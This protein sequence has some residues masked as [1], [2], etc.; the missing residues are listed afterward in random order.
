MADFVFKRRQRPIRFSWELDQDGCFRSFSDEFAQL[1]GPQDKGLIGLPFD[2]VRKKFKMG[3]IPA[4]TKSIRKQ[5]AFASVKVF[6]PACNSNKVVPI[7]LTGQPYMDEAGQF[8]G[9]HGFGV[10]RSADA[11]KAEEQVEPL[12]VLK[13]LRENLLGD[14]AQEDEAAELEDSVAAIV[15][16]AVAPTLEDAAALESV[17]I[18]VTEVELAKGIADALL[19]AEDNPTDEQEDDFTAPGFL[20]TEPEIPELVLGFE[21]S[22]AEVETET[23]EPVEEKTSEASGPEAE[24]L[25]HPEE[26][27][28]VAPH[29][30]PEPTEDDGVVFAEETP[31]AEQE[32]LT[33]ADE[34]YGEDEPEF[35]ENYIAEQEYSEAYAQDL[36]VAADESDDTPDLNDETADEGLPELASD[37]ITD[38]DH[39]EDLERFAADAFDTEEAEAEDGFADVAEPE[40]LAPPAPPVTPMRPTTSAEDF[41]RAIADLPDAPSKPKRNGPRSLAELTSSI[42]RFVDKNPSI[43]R[44][45]SSLSKPEQDAFE[46]IARALGAENEPASHAANDA[47]PVDTPKPADPEHTATPEEAAEKAVAEVGHVPAS[48]II[49]LP[50]ETPAAEPP[51]QT[52]EHDNATV[53]DN[54][55]HVV[56]PRVPTDIEEA[57]AQARTKN[58]RIPDK[59]IVAPIDPRLLDRLP[60]GVAIVRERDVVY[61][62]D[63]LLELLGYERFEALGQAGGL[64]AIFAEPEECPAPTSQTVDREVH[65]RLA[66]GGVL[67]V[68]AR[69]HAVPWDNA[70]ALMI[71]V[72]GKVPV[73]EDMAPIPSVTEVSPV[74]EG[75]LTRA[76]AR[77]AELESVLATATDG[78][79]VVNQSGVIASA[80]HSAEALFGAQSDDLIGAS[81]T[82]Y[83]AGESHVAVLDYLDGLIA[84]GVSSVLNDGREVICKTLDGDVFPTFLSMGRVTESNEPQFC[85]VLRD[86]TQFKRAEEELVSARLK[87]EEANAHKSEYL[88][89]VTHEIRTPLNAVIGFSEVMQQ[90][91][92][93]ELGNVRYK[94]YARDINRSCTHMLHLIN[95]LLDLAKIE[96]GRM[97]IAFEAVSAAD[98]INECVAL[99]QPQANEQRVI[100]RASAPHSVPKVVADPTT[101]RQIVLNLLSN[102][103]KFNKSGGQVIVSL[104]MDDSGEVKLRIRDT[105]KGMSQE[106]VDAAMEPFRRLDAPETTEGSGLGL[107]LTKALVEA[108]RANFSILSEEDQGTLVEVT[109]PQQ[110]VLAE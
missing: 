70:Q 72:V 27:V 19:E 69:M 28:S 5:K 87:A 66:T 4:I 59:P 48:N 14:A 20:R 37:E 94:E 30:E 53:G 63:T 90:E 3:K 34:S 25:D 9:Y 56:L 67:A 93:G 95:D 8:A 49:P 76:E 10:I 13:K 100:I 80:N 11:K 64:E 35:H 65:V 32:E 88:T 22:E 55:T 16:K 38:A 12:D 104:L 1:L 71:S 101:L 73:V 43:S 15:D 103:I 40:E 60:I 46:K 85:A 61:A 42:V 83:I 33:E 98:I 79:L 50:A 97:D 54:V 108:N 7:D 18:A 23:S 29:F 91:R 24:V 47:A 102:A 77:I 57:A 99:L 78:V 2:A 92:F 96:A 107:P 21:D 41:Q 106:Q 44:E 84:N 68:D 6:W 75:Q 81:I 58:G 52:V 62:N 74:S 36:E 45:P 51:V 89:K 17:P 109:F 82:D 39:E 86:I 26:I 31:D 105:G 110:R